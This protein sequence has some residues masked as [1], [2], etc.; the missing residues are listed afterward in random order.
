MLQYNSWF[1][2]VIV[3]LQFQIFVQLQ[4]AVIMT[5][6]D[7]KFVKTNPKKIQV[8]HLTNG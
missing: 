7:G 3:Q 5:N 1:I 2:W 6:P 4:G 8:N